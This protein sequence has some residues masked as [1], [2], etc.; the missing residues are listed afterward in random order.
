MCAKFHRKTRGAVKV[1]YYLNFTNTTQ[2]EYI[3]MDVFLT[4]RFSLEGTIPGTTNLHEFIQQT[5]KQKFRQ[6]HFVLVKSGLNI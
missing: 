6:N 1:Y 5:V 2:E 3:E 4:H